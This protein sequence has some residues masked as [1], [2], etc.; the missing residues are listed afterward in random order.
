MAV[1]LNPQHYGELIDLFRGR[2]DLE[3]K[4]IRVL[5]DNSFKDDATR[6]WR[7]IRYEQRLG[8]NIEPHTLD[9][10]IKDIAYLDS[11]SGDR[12]RH[13][14][15]LCLE[16]DYPEKI[17]LRANELGLLIRICPSLKVDQWIA[18]IISKARGIMQPYCPPE[19]LYLSILGYRLKKEDLEDLITYLKFSRTTAR[20]LQDTLSL[21]EKLPELAEPELAPSRVYRLLHEYDPT[22]I[23]ANLLAG[24]TA[25]IR[26]QIESYLNKMRFVHPALTGDDLKE[27]GIDSGPRIKQILELLLEARLDGRVGTREEEI[28]MVLSRIS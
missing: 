23:L 11:I 17:L 28:R 16:E 9:L 13:E 19:E 3:H 7:A 10:V 26:E 14:L 6:I 15:E 27:M 12:I 24:D 5:H 1:D 22:A 2:E 8:F 20:I 4:F 25:Q 18:K 21:K